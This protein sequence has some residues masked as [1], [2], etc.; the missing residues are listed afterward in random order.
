MPYGTENDKILTSTYVWQNGTLPFVVKLWMNLKNI[1]EIVK[2]WWIIKNSLAI[3]CNV[4][5]VSALSNFLYKYKS[6]VNLLIIDASA[7]ELR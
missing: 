1:T 7:V 3:C 4:G 6:G 2:S 5:D